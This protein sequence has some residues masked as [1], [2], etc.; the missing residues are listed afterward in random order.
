MSGLKTLSRLMMGYLNI[1]A[2]KQWTSIW[3]LITPAREENS[4]TVFNEQ[5]KEQNSLNV[6]HIDN[7]TDSLKHHKYDVT[8]M[9][10]KVIKERWD[11][12][13]NPSHA[14]F[15]KISLFVNGRYLFLFFLTGGHR[16][17]SVRC[18][19]DGCRIKERSK[20]PSFIRS[21]TGVCLKMNGK[22][23]RTS[24]F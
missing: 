10:H 19:S 16:Q 7:K 21:F 11:C 17:M 23:F 6:S 1:T 2:C 15:S 8:W 14:V 13:L 3:A 9:S 22:S 18:P 5:K 20:K 4:W 12:D 24:K